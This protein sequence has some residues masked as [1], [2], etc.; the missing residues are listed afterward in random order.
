MNP[1]VVY[2]IDGLL[3]TLELPIPSTITDARAHVVKVREMTDPELLAEIDSQIQRRVAGGQ[4]EADASRVV[5]R[6]WRDDAK[7]LLEVAI[8]ESAPQLLQVKRAA[9]FELFA[10]VRDLGDVPQDPRQAMKVGPAGIEGFDR[11]EAL[12]LRYGR[13]FRLHRLL[14]DG[15][16]PHGRQP[17]DPT[18]WALFGDTQHWTSKPDDGRGHKKAFGLQDEP[19]AGEALPVRL[20][21]LVDHA[22]FWQPDAEECTDFY[23]EWLP[24]AGESASR[25]SVAKS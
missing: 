11:W 23:I 1:T 16:D 22:D 12:A 2:Q 20:R 6:T 10:D 14:L 25:L 15:D 24:K 8:E 17:V 9:T 21:F 7:R 4:S 5:T 19:Y 3:K 13:L 18:A